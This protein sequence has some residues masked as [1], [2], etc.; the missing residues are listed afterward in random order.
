MPTTSAPTPTSPAWSSIVGVSALNTTPNAGHLKITLKPRDARKANV[1]A[2]ID[3]LKEKVGAI[4]GVT[5]YFQPV[6]DVQISTRISRAQYQYTLVGS[7]E[8]D[9]ALWSARLAE[10]LRS[11]PVLREVVSE[12]QDGGLRAMVQRRPRDG[13]A[14]RRLHAGHQRCAQRRLRPAPDLHHLRPGQPVPR[15]ARGHAAVPERPRRA[16]A[17]LRSGHRRRTGAA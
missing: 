10:R 11:S 12:A 13:R 4:P 1:T 16:V 8:K 6:Q 5:V 2:I 17:A 14:P 7:D 9:V 15:R 3:R